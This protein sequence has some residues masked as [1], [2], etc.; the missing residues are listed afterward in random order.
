MDKIADLIT[1]ESILQWIIILLIVGYFVYKEWPELKRR[2]TSGVKKE[3]AEESQAAS[4]NERLTKIEQR[5][6]A[7]DGKLNSDYASLRNLENEE[8][9][10]RR[11][12]KDSLEEREIIMRAL[13]GVIG[14]LQEL[15]ANG[16]TKDAQSEI[17]MYLA[18]QAHRTETE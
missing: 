11:M 10:D 15:G 7:I 2:I 1:A 16:P 17:T 6:D 4:V 18:K 9:R 3:Q 14:G 5:L 13:L 12:F 8:A